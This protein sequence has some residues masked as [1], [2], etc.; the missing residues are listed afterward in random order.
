MK[1]SL[2]VSFS[3]FSSF[4]LT[5]FQAHAATCDMGGIIFKNVM[6]GTGIGAGVG[7]L[8]QLANSNSSHIIP[9]I[10]TS[11]LIGAGIGAVVGVV[12][13]SYSENCAKRKKENDDYALNLKFKPLVKLA[14][15]TNA[16]DGIP[17]PHVVKE[18]PGAG[19]T[20]LYSL[21]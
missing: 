1:R 19:L 11:A 5:P 8:V 14:N 13:I 10:A 17:F 20:V 9:N 18:K 7:A 21:D 4:L 2:L 3:V 16:N 12:E 6:Y 15:T